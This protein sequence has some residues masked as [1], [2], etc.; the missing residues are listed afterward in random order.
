MTNMF[1]G[2]SPAPGVGTLIVKISLFK[3]LPRR[4][5]L[6]HILVLGCLSHYLAVR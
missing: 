3:H 1:G 4:P 5:L 2:D 6:P